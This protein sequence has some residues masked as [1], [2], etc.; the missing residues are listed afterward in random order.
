MRLPL[1]VLTFFGNSDLTTLKYVS[2]K[3]GQIGMN[4]SWASV[5]ALSAS[6]ALR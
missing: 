2:E 1:L 4:I 3:F 5:T 6:Q